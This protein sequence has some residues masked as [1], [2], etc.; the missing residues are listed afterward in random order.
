MKFVC[1]PDECRCQRLAF[2]HFSC[3]P[4]LL[5]AIGLT[6]LTLHAIALD[7]VFEVPFRYTDEYLN[8]FFVTFALL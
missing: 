4:C 3:E 7:S 1:Q 2:W 5:T 8:R 6:N